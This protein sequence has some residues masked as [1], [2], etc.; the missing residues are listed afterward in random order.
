MSAI[1]WK[2]FSSYCDPNKVQNKDGSIGCAVGMLFLPKTEPELSAHIKI[3]ETVMNKSGFEVL[4][5]RD[6]PVD[7][8]ILGSLSADFVPVIKQVVVRGG[9]TA[10]G[11][12]SG[13]DTSNDIEKALY[14]AR[15]EI[16]GLFRQFDFDFTNAYVCSLSSKTIIYKGI[17]II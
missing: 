9:S 17:Y 1:P 5:F 13:F 14:D 6:V 2:L 3:V 15:R 16:H 10:N 7:K 11:M 8:T 4:G 12:S